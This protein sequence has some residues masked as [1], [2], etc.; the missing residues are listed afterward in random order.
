MSNLDFECQ[1]IEIY[2]KYLLGLHLMCTPRL[3]SHKVNAEAA[4][5][6]SV[7]L[8]SLNVRVYEW[9]VSTPYPRC[10]AFFVTIKL[11]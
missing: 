4:A 8:R 11:V 10:S 7:L 3:T 5:G 9:N 6:V 1:G 2:L